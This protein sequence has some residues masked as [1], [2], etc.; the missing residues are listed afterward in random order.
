M[1]SKGT[2]GRPKVQLDAPYPEGSGREADLH[3]AAEPPGAVLQL[4]SDRPVSDDDADRLGYGVYADALA[5]LLDNPATDTPLTVAIDA[6]WGAGKTS[7]AHLI[8]ARLQSWPLERGEPPHVVCWFNA[9]LHDEAP[10]VGAALAA[11]VARTADSYRPWWRRLTTTLPT[12]FLSAGQRLRRTLL[13]AL[14]TVLASVVLVLAAQ[15]TGPE[16]WLSELVRSLL[17]GRGPQEAVPVVVV[18]AVLTLLVWRRLFPYAQN[19]ATF[20]DDP[21]AEA[22]RGSVGKVREQLGELLAQVTHGRRFVIFVDDLERC[23]PPS[24]LDVCE[25]AGQLLAHPQ[26]VTVLLADMSTSPGWPRPGTDS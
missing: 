23:R 14:A 9:W 21:R 11:E 12:T 3:R 1:R 18:V 13:L 16:H 22:A 24:P 25:T 6:E 17:P 8:A 15:R 5:E 19:L 4:F 20:L 10:S 26:V 2:G 7:L